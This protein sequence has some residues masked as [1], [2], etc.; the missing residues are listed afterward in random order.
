[1]GF[2]HAATAGAAQIRALALGMLIH[3][4]G[5]AHFPDLLVEIAADGWTD[6]EP[7]ASN[8]DL[9]P[10][11]DEDLAGSAAA[12]TVSETFET[13]AAATLVLERWEGHGCRRS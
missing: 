8:L 9:V 13:G 2:A 11:G 3:A 7:V 10:D 12:V 1:M 4:G 5:A 6:P